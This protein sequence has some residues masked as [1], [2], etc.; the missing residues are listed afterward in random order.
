[1]GY[2]VQP[3]FEWLW[4]CCCIIMTGVL[5]WFVVKLEGDPR[6]QES[7]SILNTM[8]L[9][10]S[11]A[12]P[13]VRLCFRECLLTDSCVGAIAAGFVQQLEGQLPSSVVRKNCHLADLFS[14]FHENGRH[15]NPFCARFPFRAGDKHSTTYR[16]VGAIDAESYS[17]LSFQG[18]T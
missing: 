9:L 11:R 5:M 14:H 7:K 10:T 3:N 2:Q 15:W 8:Y 12:S 6:R 17:N 4:C 18:S 13:V 1:M 16:R